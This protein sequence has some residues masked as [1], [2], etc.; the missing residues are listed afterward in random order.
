M[1]RFSPGEYT[2]LPT[3]E[4]EV[5]LHGESVGG[6]TVALFLVAHRIIRLAVKTAVVREAAARAALDVWV[7]LRGREFLAAYLTGRLE[8]RQDL[9]DGGQV[10]HGPCSCSTKSDNRNSNFST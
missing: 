3:S 6:G 8:F 9:T 5:E 7:I 4:Q 10:R 1:S 2:N